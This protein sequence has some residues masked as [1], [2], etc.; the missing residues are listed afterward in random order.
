MV[1]RC[2]ASS[3]RGVW[4]SASSSRVAATSACR[5]RDFCWV[6]PVETYGTGIA[7]MVP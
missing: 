4:P 3:T 1:A 5:V 6:R 7:I 2:A